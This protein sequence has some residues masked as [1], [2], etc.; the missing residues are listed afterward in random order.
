MAG[1]RRKQLIKA[2]QW[3]KLSNATPLVAFLPLFILWFGLRLL[4][5]VFLSSMTPIVIGN[6]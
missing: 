4:V 6:E 5:K 2:G 1:L 3:R